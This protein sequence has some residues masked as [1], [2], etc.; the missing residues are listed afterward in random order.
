VR[1][2]IKSYW[3]TGAF[4]VD[5]VRIEDIDLTACEGFSVTMLLIGADDEVLPD[6]SLELLVDA[7]PLVFSYHDLHIPS[8]DVVKLAFEVTEPPASP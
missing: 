7:N 2:T 6:G 3:S 5:V 4:Y 1:L 8:L